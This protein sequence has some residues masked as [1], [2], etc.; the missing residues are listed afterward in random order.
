LD[1]L[2]LYT[3]GAAQ[4]KGGVN[5]IKSLAGAAVG[6]VNTALKNSGVSERA[7]LVATEKINHTSSGNL[8]SDISKIANDSQVASWRTK[9]KADLVSM[10]VKSSSGNTM[11]MGHVGTAN[12]NKGAAYSVCKVKAIG[13]PIRSFAH[14]VG[15]NLGC[16]HAKDQGS[17]AGTGAFGYSHGWRF[18]G[19]DKKKYRTLLSYQKNPGEAR[20]PYYSNPSVQYKGTATGTSA[21]DNGKTIKAVIKKAIKYY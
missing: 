3:D 10:L 19:T 7:K 14:E 2:V 9:Y 6:N 13:G 1:I 12:G 16:A 15:H 21:A 4:E 5:G 18:E 8:G 17:G 11:G 20:I